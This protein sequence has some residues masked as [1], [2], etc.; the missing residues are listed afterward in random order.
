MRRRAWTR[1]SR[2]AG[3]TGSA[4]C[5]QKLAHTSEDLGRVT[6]TMATLAQQFLSEWLARIAVHAVGE[7]T[8]KTSESAHR[9]IRGRSSTR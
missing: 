4:R 8:P 3:R 5:G 1:L 7:V 2:P 9:Q 6:P